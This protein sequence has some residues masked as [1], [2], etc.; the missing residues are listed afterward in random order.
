ML[1]VFEKEKECKYRLPC[2]WCDRQDR[3]CDLVQLDIDL[4]EASR[5]AAEHPCAG[6]KTGWGSMSTLGIKTCHDTCE[7]LAEWN[8]RNGNGEM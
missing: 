4:A 1:Q 5:V 6:C 3:M 2:G 8:R 7:R